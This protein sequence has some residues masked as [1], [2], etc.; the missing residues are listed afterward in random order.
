MDGGKVLENSTAR[1]AQVVRDPTLVVDFYSRFAAVYEVWGNL[2]DGRVRR[3][4]VSVASVADG[5]AVL[6]V[7]CGDGTFLELF[8][9]ANPSGRTV[10]IDLAPG[11]RARAR[12]RLERAHLDAEVHPGDARELA[13]GD[14]SFDAL[15]CAYVLDI[16]PDEEIEQ[17]LGE[18]R[19]VLRP[20]GRL[21]VANAGR[22]LRRRHRLPELLYGTRLPFSSLC[23][24]IDSLAKVAAA[25]FRDA[26]CEYSAQFLFPTELVVASR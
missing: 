5:D 6:D 4:M 1:A 24:P 10:G 15:T 3:R 18:F 7:G 26:R 17:A 22:A 13:F 19:R 9:R 12:R 25:G 2:V 21:V 11:M 20:G 8:A 14:A 16:L 23:R